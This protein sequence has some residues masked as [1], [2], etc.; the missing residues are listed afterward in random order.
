M[1]RLRA[2]CGRRARRAARRRSRRG[3]APRTS[4]R[5]WY[6]MPEPRRSSATLVRVAGTVADVRACAG[7]A[8]G[9]ASLAP[10]SA[11]VALGARSTPPAPARP[12]PP[13]LALDRASPTSPGVDRDGGTRTGDPTLYVT[14]QRGVGSRDP[15]RHAVADAGARPHRPSDRRRRAGSARASR[16][17][18]TARTLYV[19][20]TDRERRHADRRVRDERAQR[21][22][23]RRGAR[24]LAVPQPQPNHNG[25][26]LAFGPDG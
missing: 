1:A 19:D 4:R 6:A 12:R 22:S 24:S 18:P 17:R 25:G 10:R 7:V 20:Y 5:Q 3:R 8:I 23:R 13:S 21:R 9:V 11:V 15:Q 14:E 2:A 16:S 26:Q